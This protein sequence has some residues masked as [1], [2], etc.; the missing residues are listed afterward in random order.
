VGE[1]GEGAALGERR[2]AL[3]GMRTALQDPAGSE[4]EFMR[5]PPGGTLTQNTKGE[6]KPIKSMTEEE[7]RT[8]HDDLEKR[9]EWGGDGLTR[10]QRNRMVS[11]RNRL[12]RIQAKRRK[13]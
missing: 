10:N 11:L 2:S 3:L 12:K 4:I 7:L 8:E 6:M 5:R 13:T 9:L 1:I